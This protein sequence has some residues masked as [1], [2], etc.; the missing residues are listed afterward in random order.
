LTQ[1]CIAPSTQS[2]LSHTTSNSLSYLFLLSPFS[3]SFLLA[4]LFRY[5]SCG[6]SYIALVIILALLL[7]SG[8]G[9]GTV[10]TSVNFVGGTASCTNGT[11]SVNQTYLPNFAC[12]DGRGEWN[13]GMLG[14]MDPIPP[15]SGYV[16]HNLTATVY[17]RFDCNG[18][19]SD[20]IIGIIEINGI[21]HTCNTPHYHNTTTTPQ[22][23]LRTGHIAGDAILPTSTGECSCPKC[24]LGA[25]FKSTIYTNGLSNYEY[26]QNNTLQFQA[27]SA[28]PDVVC[29]SRIDLTFAYGP[30]S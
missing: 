11:C 13:D 1:L 15:N 5:M 16:L 21:I 12:S 3:P 2:R 14:F 18:T 7:P 25:V 27:M 4:S 29:V 17:G 20:D 8:Q 9:Q 23:I 24:V 10:S 19:Y 26:G 28:F 30:S 22:L 6:W